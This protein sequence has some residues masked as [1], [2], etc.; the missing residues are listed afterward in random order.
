[1]DAIAADAAGDQVVAIAR[2]NIHGRVESLQ[3]AIGA[4]EE[5]DLDDLTAR[6]V[7]LQLADELVS[8]CVWIGDVQLR[9]DQRVFLAIRQV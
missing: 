6:K 3:H 4:R 2:V 8:D 7:L 9:E 1:V 5:H